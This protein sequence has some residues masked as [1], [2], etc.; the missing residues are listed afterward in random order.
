MRCLREMLR[1]FSF[2]RPVGGTLQMTKARNAGEARRLDDFPNSGPAMVEDFRNLG[3]EQLGRLDGEGPSP[4]S[5]RTSAAT[6]GAHSP[7]SRATF[8]P[9]VRYTD[10][11]QRPH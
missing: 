9:A 4:L 5:G 11:R 6:C 2:R 7:Y 10:G 1:P 8:P 3:I